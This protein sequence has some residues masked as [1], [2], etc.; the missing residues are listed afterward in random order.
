[1]FDFDLGLPDPSEHVITVDGRP[2][3]IIPVE[4]RELIPRHIC[5][6]YKIVPLSVDTSIRVDNGNGVL[7]LASINILDSDVRDKLE[8]MTGMGIR[9]KFTDMKSINNAIDKYITCSFGDLHHSECFQKIVLT[10]IIAVG[11]WLTT[12]YLHH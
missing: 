1:M 10:L 4:V 7:T 11:L 8:M 6:K 2:D 5:R 9:I 12:Y 3:L